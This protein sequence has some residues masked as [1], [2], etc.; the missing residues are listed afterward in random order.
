MLRRN[1]QDFTTEMHSD[2]HASY[3]NA[4]AKSFVP[5]RISPQHRGEFFADIRTAGAGDVVF[6]EIASTAQTV[7]RT[8]CEISRGGSS[9]Y[10]V[11]LL[12]AGTSILVQDGRELVMQAGDLTLY[13]TSRPYSLLFDGE[14][15]NLIM[16]FPKNSLS[17]PVA[18][19]EHL[20]AAPLSAMHPLAP[21]LSAFITNFSQQFSMLAGATRLQ[22]A[23][24]SL[25]LAKNLFTEVLGLHPSEQD[26]RQSLLSKIGKYIEVHLPSPDLTPSS[27][28]AAHYISTRYLHT[29]FTETGTTV[30]ALIKELRLERCHADLVDSAQ[31]T[32]GVAA[33]GAQWGFLDAAHF[34]RI[35]RAANGMSPTEFRRFHSEP[36]SR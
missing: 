13:D 29:L 15:R 34:S 11:S 33:I 26:T 20:S 8:S 36:S 9:Y 21:I 5:L 7:E 22:L 14:F 27:I 16:M 6:T 4:I 17:A 31:A 10:K 2:D 12:L 30:A 25:D 23:D 32:R 35:F 24:T 19:L 28:A 1:V 18:S 3:L